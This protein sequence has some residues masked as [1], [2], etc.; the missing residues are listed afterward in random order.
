MANV[1]TQRRVGEEL[2]A[3]LTQMAAFLN[4]DGVEVAGIGNLAGVISEC[5]P[6]E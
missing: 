2:A 1:A 4:L 3:E 6:S 5:V